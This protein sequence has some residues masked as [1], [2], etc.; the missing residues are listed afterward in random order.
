MD[1]NSG[2]DLSQ[3]GKPVIGSKPIEGPIIRLL[4]CLVCNS[5]EELPDYEGPSNHDY[6]LE[7][8]LEKHV[9]PSGDPHV[10]KLFKIP[11]KSWANEEQKQAILQQ[12]KDGGSRGLDDLT[13][14]KNFYETKMTFAQEAMSCW[15]KHNKP[16]NDCEDYQS[17]AKR[18]LP[19]TAKERGEL[20]LPKP[21]HLDGPKIYTC[22]FCPYH[23]EVIQRRRKIMGMYN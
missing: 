12:F 20:G 5:L 11:V 4:M 23:G 13:E 8:S 18:L 10:G 1:L 3:L 9:F 7:I 6:L 16:T 17:P 22:N 19:D 21:E 2:M 14:E 15:Q